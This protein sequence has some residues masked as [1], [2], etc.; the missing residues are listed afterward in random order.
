MGGGGGSSGYD[1]DAAHAGRS[2]EVEETGERLEGM[3]GIRR[4]ER[5]KDWKASEFG[6]WCPV[7]SRGPKREREWIGRPDGWEGPLQCA[8]KVG[9]LCTEQLESDGGNGPGRSARRG[10]RR[11][12]D[13]R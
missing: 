11:V 2:N 3:G 7:R 13:A 8:G 10:E 12:T 4:K 1:C 5:K 9:V 6:I